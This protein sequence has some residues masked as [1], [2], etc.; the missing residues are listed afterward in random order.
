MPDVNTNLTNHYEDSYMKFD[1]AAHMIEDRED[2]NNFHK[3]EATTQICSILY[4]FVNRG[5]QDLRDDVDLWETVH[6]ADNV[7]Q[8]LRNLRTLFRAHSDENQAT[9][10]EFALQLSKCWHGILSYQQLATSKE[11]RAEAYDRIT[12]LINL[13]NRYPTADEHSLGHYLSN[14]AGENWLPFPFMGI[15]NDLFDEQLELKDKSNL[16]SVIKIISHI[17]ESF[18]VHS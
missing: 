5:L 7:I 4:V 14:H 15:L 11:M 18:N 10:L 2:K 13:F 16:I 1:A 3:L 12:K 9:S 8:H 17:I 6:I